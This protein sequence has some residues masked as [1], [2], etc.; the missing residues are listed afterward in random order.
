VNVDL[1]KWPVLLVKG[2]KITPEQADRVILRT[3]WLH[4]VDSSNRKWNSEVKKVFSIRGKEKLWCTDWEEW[5]RISARVG[6]LDLN[7]LHNDR[8]RS[9][10]VSGPD[11]WCGW[12]GRIGCSGISLTSK[13]PE[14]ADIQA[15]WSAIAH[16]FPFLELT[17]Q[18]ARVEWD[19]SP[20]GWITGHTPLVTWDVGRG[21]AA[22]RDDAGPLL[23][24]LRTEPE[25]PEEIDAQVRR[26]LSP[27]GD[28]GVR[29]RRLRDAVRRCERNTR[30]G[31]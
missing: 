31:K 3:S 25:T 29:V 12:D 19:D 24:P 26:V 20:G 22:L 14:V 23:F 10:S 8:I 16:A 28:V 17:A 9:S 15:E 5:D 30:K 21:A 2:K 6:S 1:P 11:G 7:Y 18:L 4:V 13:W 27:C